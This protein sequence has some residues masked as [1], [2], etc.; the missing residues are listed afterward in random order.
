MQASNLAAQ[1]AAKI[2]TAVPAADDAPSLF[3]IDGFTKFATTVFG[4]V[5]IL[6]AIYMGWRSKK[7]KVSENGN[8]LAN[9]GLASVVFIFGAMGVA[10]PYAKSI[11]SFFT[12]TDI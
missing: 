9:V 5:L 8:I 3:K 2:T 11:L 4:L 10:L 6:T 7:A 12:N 1:V